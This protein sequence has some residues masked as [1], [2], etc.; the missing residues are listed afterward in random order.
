MADDGLWRW[1]D[2]PQPPRGGGRQGL[3]QRR[4]LRPREV[5]GGSQV[6]AL[7]AAPFR[8]GHVPPPQ[9]VGD[10]AFPITGNGQQARARAQSVADPGGI[11]ASVFLGPSDSVWRWCRTAGPCPRQPA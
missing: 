2:R 9:A 11:F 5:H 10:R 4:Q 7:L 3:E 6:A 1:L 8:Q